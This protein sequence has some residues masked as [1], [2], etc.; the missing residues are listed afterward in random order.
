MAEVVAAGRETEEQAKR[1]GK[2]LESKT[3]TLKTGPAH[4]VLQG[5]SGKRL[6]WLHGISRPGP[7]DALLNALAEHFEVTAP[8]LPGYEDR[9]EL[10]GL[11]DI[12][13][14]ALHYDSVLAALGLD[15]AILAGH[16]FGGMLA[17]EIAALSPHRFEKLVLAAPLGLWNDAYPIEDLF[18]LPFAAIEE[19]LWKGAEHPPAPAS[20]ENAE[21]EDVERLVKIAN[22]VGGVAKYT[23]PIPDKGLRRRLYRLNMP[24]L[25]AFAQDDALLPAAYAE[26]F[27]AGIGDT[28]T[29]LSKGSHMF[30]NEAPERM[31]EAIAGF[32]AG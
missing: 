11:Q 12:R 25:L 31:A 14:L 10:A 16:S 3:V 20:G 22:T 26:E 6:I 4:Q 28:Q 21:E 30:P 8:L 23:W 5:G 9:D 27:A 17:G 18:A 29:L 1:G 24:T 13:D 7:D 15:G 19:L 32:A 2:V